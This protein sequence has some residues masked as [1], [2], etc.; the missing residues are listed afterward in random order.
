MSCTPR[1]TVGTPHGRQRDDGTVGANSDTT[2]VPTAAARWAGPVLPT[3]TAS[4]PASTLA[5]PARPVT[6]P[7]STTPGRTGGPATADVS[8]V[9]S[10]A[11][12]TTTWRPAS[13]KASTRAALAA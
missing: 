8:R 5:R 13:T 1:T 3:T 10:G 11:P 4:A 6:P 9:S 2:G 12:V 7:R